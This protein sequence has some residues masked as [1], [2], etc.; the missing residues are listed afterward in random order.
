MFVYMT[1]ETFPSVI[2]CEESSDGHE[3]VR[4]VHQFGTE[5]TV[6]GHGRGSVS[7]DD[8]HAH[9]LADDPNFLASLS[10][11]DDGLGGPSQSGARPLATPALPVVVSEP[12][13][14][15][16]LDLFPAAPVTRLTAPASEIPGIPGIPR[17]PGIPPMGQ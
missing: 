14:R 11:L 5:C 2:K 10:D 3:V 7:R 9:R 12:G 8:P 15:P 1:I 4:D 16:L 6:S 13:R 17:I